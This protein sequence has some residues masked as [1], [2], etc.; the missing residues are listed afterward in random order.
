MYRKCSNECFENAKSLLES[1]EALLKKKKYAIA[2]SLSITALE[3]V[4]KSI[5]LELVELSLFDKSIANKVICIHKRKTAI[6]LGLKNGLVIPDQKNADFIGYVDQGR[7]KLIGEKTLTELDLLHEKREKGLYVDV[8]VD[9]GKIKSSPKDC[10]KSEALI[11]IKNSN[12]F[13]I[14]GKTLVKKLRNIS[15]EEGTTIN[16]FRISQEDVDYFFSFW[17]NAKIL[18]KTLTIGYDE[19]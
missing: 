19:A 13:R 18:D 17:N 4:G 3:E 8:D 10:S 1:A 9:T 5:I 14:F 7:L 11:T 15:K 2:Q 6:M 12:D 16:N